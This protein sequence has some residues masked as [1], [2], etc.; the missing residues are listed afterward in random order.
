MKIENSVGINI[1]YLGYVVCTAKILFKIQLAFGVLFYIA[2]Y[3]MRKLF[4]K[5][6]AEK[7]TTQLLYR[8]H[9]KHQ[10][11]KAKKGYKSF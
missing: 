7:Q 5:L 3:T 4:L 10:H 11:H 9:L 8:Q 6:I 2:A 1:I